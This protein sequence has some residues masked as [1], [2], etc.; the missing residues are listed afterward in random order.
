VLAAQSVK[1]NR[2][3]ALAVTGPERSSAL[4]DVPTFREAGLPAFDASVMFGIM[5]PKGLPRPIV[6]RIN[7][8]VGEVLKDPAVQAQLVK[9]GGLHLTPG[10]PEQFAKLIADD[11]A[12]WKKVAGPMGIRAE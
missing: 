11:I 8:E 12:K 3:R 4:P 1:T 5:G 10:T 6:E 7:R 9:T 2:V